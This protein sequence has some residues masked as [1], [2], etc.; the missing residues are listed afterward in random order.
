M[1]TL[2]RGVNAVPASHAVFAIGGAVYVE[3]IVMLTEA[4]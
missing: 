3:P 1:R 2:A 4:P